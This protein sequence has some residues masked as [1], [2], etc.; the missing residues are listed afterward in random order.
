MEERMMG[1]SRRSRRDFL[2]LA[3]G[4]T[5]AVA[6]AGSLGVLLDACGGNPPAPAKPTAADVSALYAAAKTE[7]KVVWYTAQFEL[8]QAQ[9]VIAAF[10]AKFPG[11]DVDLTRQTSQIIAQRTLQDFEK[12]AFTIDVVGT[13]DEGNFVD[14]KKK[15]A[16]LA[17]TPP[18]ISLL[19][20]RFQKL[21]ADGNY[22]MSAIAL[23]I[24]SY[25][26]KLVS[27]P[28][29]VW[30]DMLDPKWSGKITLGHPGYSGQVLN[31]VLATVDKYGWSYFQDMAKLNPKIGR[32]INDTLTDLKAGER[33]IGASAAS[34]TLG[35]KA[36][37]DP[38]EVRY[39]DDYTVLVV[40]PQAVLKNAPHPNAAKLFQNF[41]YSRECSQVMTDTF[42]PPIRTDVK[43]PS[44]MDLEKIKTERVAV[45]RLTKGLPEAKAKWREIMG[46]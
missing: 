44:G 45:D 30:K 33:Q 13:A 41:N 6:G 8:S 38:V 36:K 15:G 7:G 29:K 40:Q 24:I 19:P 46:V 37:G 27:D 10:K 16:L 23:I 22:F 18:D 42:Q 35:F 26:T 39:P 2:Q 32:S 25:S 11:I 9:A 17:Y 1:D 34:V 21:D 3:G 4:A 20:Q 43:G 28:P 5:M 12:G 14:F 31:W